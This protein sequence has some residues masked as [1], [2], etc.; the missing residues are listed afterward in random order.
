MWRAL[1]ALVFNVA[2]AVAF[3]AFGASLSVS[4]LT[5]LGLMVF[6]GVAELGQHLSLIEDKLDA[7]IGK[8]GASFDGI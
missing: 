2:V 8:K 5:F 7:I 3:H 6:A 1:I 4:W